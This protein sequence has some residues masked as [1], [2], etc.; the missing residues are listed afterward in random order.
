MATATRQW[1]PSTI[2]EPGVPRRIMRLGVNACAL[3]GSVWL[4]VNQRDH[5]TVKQKR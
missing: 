1:K 2:A 5:S 4:A 3:L